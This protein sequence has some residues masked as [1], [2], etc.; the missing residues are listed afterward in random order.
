ML[1]EFI[2]SISGTLYERDDICLWKRL[3]QKRWLQAEKLQENSKF[4]LMI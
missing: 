4:G 2:L 3:S 1:Q